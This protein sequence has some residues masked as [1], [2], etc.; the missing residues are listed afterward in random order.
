MQQEFKESIQN[1]VDDIKSKKEFDL[2]KT[3]KGELIL[4]NDVVIKAKVEHMMQHYFSRVEV[5]HGKAMIVASSRIAA[6]RY[7]ETIVKMYPNMKEKIILVLSDDN[8]DTE[9]LISKTMVPRHKL[10]E[11]EKE[12]RKDNSKYKIAIV[13]AMWLTGYDC[14][15][16]DCLYLDKILK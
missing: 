2:D 5:L 1:E 13:C 16:L 15:D 12:F 9:G 14:P 8:K 6:Y 11:V 3:L 7:Y 10:D 4:D